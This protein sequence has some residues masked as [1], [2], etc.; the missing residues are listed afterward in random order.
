[1]NGRRIAWGT[2]ATLAI[3]AG[4]SLPAPVLAEPEVVETAVT[5]VA[6]EPSETDDVTAEVDDVSQE[7]EAP[8]QEQEPAADAEESTAEA[9]EKDAKAGDDTEAAKDGAFKS[10]LTGAYEEF[11]TGETTETADGLRVASS[12]GDYMVRWQDKG[13]SLGDMVYSADVSFESADVDGAASLVLHSDDGALGAMQSYVANVNP[14]TGEC[15]LFKFE[16]T[17]NEG[18]ISYNMLT[19]I[20]LGASVSDTFHL[21]V[22]TIGK[23][24]VFSVSYKDAEGNTVTKTASTADYTLGTADNNEEIYAH[25][26]QNTALREGY[27]GLLSFNAAVTYQNV[28]A[29][30]LTESNTPQLSSLNITGD[31]V[32]MPFA[33]QDTA[34][35]YVGYVRNSA[36]SV[37][38][39]YETTNADARVSVADEA[40]NVY[41]TFTSLRAGS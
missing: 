26:G 31:A 18:Y 37:N 33:F 34:Y 32:D 36:D 25:Y 6:Q 23:H 21:S 11:G 16:Q 22:T 10:N 40:G 29:T 1:M 24:M 12:G 5:D 17:A 15:R 13:A 9:A 27:C 2:A 35:V 41:E 20:Q 28:M 14:K 7:T 30:P 19:P 38:I 8:S 3:V 39:A 4:L